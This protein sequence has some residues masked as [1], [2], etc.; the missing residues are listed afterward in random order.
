MVGRLRLDD[1]SDSSRLPDEEL[2]PP[3][4]RRLAIIATW[5]CDKMTREV[6]G[7]SGRAAVGVWVPATVDGPATAEVEGLAA[8]ALEGLPARAAEGAAFVGGVAGRAGDVGGDACRDEALLLEGVPRAF[9]PFLGVDL[10]LGA[11]EYWGTK[12]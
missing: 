9:P 1:A 2:A 12:R 8:A 11:I 7:D 4:P 6:V 10:F 5:D 3:F